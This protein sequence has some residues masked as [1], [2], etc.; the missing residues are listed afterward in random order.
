M[1]QPI[2]RT[3]RG[4]Q[5]AWVWMP[6][7]GGEPSLVGVSPSGRLVSGLGRP[8]PT[9]KTQ[10][11]GTWR[12]AD[13]SSIFVG[14]ANDITAYSA[15]D[16]SQQ[17]TYFRRPGN[18]VGSAFSPDGH[19]L[20]LV[21]FN[22][23]VE[24]QLLDLRTGASQELPVGHDPKADL[25]G[26]SCPGDP[27][28]DCSR[29]VVWGTVLFAP[30]SARLYTLMD[31]G[32][33]IRLTAFEIVGADLVQRATAVDGQQ[34]RSFQACGGPAIAAQVVNDG[35][36][37]VVFCHFDGVVSF[38]D[39][40]TLTSSG[41]VQSKQTNPFW[42]SPI[43][44]PDG[45][46]LYLRQAPAFGD[47]MQVID[48]RNRRLLGPVSTPT[49]PEQD[50]P[51]AWLV[52]RAYAGWVASTVP[53]SPDGLKLY[54]ATDDGVI[55][56]RIPDLKPI[57]KLAPGENTGEVWVSGDG[58]TIY[59]TTDDGKRLVVM[60]ADGSDLISVDLPAAAGG[61]IAAEHG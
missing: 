45:Q 16:G 8:I 38:F 13:G 35:H 42:L 6:S 26:M 58:Q 39:F 59:G 19:W 37:L 5:V 18:V 23:G 44:T 4:A 33:P 10:T 7:K 52:G 49:K 41:V 30:D 31:W 25:P 1:P 29:L 40:G 21:L 55:V 2:T 56:L 28:G 15:M 48:L 60:G 24:L 53:V 27:N 51:F 36:T 34:N 9:D 57:A 22:R 12:S 17:R 3:S 54:S 32:G 11:Y 46:L 47:T 50:G 43:F 14:K 61:F 20:A